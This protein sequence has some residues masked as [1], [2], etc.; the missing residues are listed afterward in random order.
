VRSQK[1]LTERLFLG[2]PNSVDSRLLETQVEAADAR[3]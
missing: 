3:E 1:R 2:H